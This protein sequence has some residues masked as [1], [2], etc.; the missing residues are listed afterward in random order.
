MAEQF[1][2]DELAHWVGLLHDIGKFHPDF[3]KYLREDSSSARVDHKGAGAWMAIDSSLHPL[4]YPLAAH[5]GGLQDKVDADDWAKKLNRRRVEEA[6]RM[7]REHLPELSSPVPQFPRWIKDKLACEFFIRMLFSSLIDADFLDTEEHFNPAASI[8]RSAEVAIENIQVRFEEFQAAFSGITD[9]PVNR[10][11]HD[12]YLACS[13][14]AGLAPGFFSLTV[15]T[16]GGK[17]RSSLSFALGHAVKHGMRRVI[18][19]IPYTSIIEQ[20]AEVYGKALAAIGEGIVLEHHSAV[21]A[22]EEE[23][24]SYTSWQRLAAENWDAPI[25]VTTAVQFFESLL[26]NKVSRCRKLHN[27]AGSVVIL[28]EVQTLPAQLLEPILD[29]LRQLVSHYNV[30]VVLCTATQPALKQS[31]Y[32]SGLPNTREIAPDPPRLFSILKRVEYEIPARKERWSWENVA[33]EILSS[34]QVLAVVN[35]RRHVLKLLDHLP[36]EHLFHLSTLLCGRHR[37]EVLREIKKRL[38]DGAPC[39][40][41]ST[42]VVEAGVDVDFPVV[43][44]AIGPLDS[45]VQSAGR[46]NREGKLMRDGRPARGRVVIFQPEEAGMP[47]GF[48]RSA[49]AIAQQLLQEEAIDLEDPVLFEKYFTR[50]YPIRPTSKEREIKDLRCSFCYSKVAARFKII[51]EETLPVVVGYPD[52]EQIMPLL[53]ELEEAFRGHSK[54]QLRGI[55]RSLQPFMVH[56]YQNQLLKHEA[57]RS[58]RR[59]APNLDLWEWLLPYDKLRGIGKDYLEPEDCIA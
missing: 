31:R 43:F 33:E 49:T 38:A 40:L 4:L 16:G 12:V 53:D 55:L 11:R 1:G 54:R 46:C 6:Q 39:R 47:G 2:A 18:F 13:E 44:R 32:L 52:K 25:V 5:H 15:P 35:T 34:D 57:S 3:Q 36:E 56:V 10:V 48:Y 42:Q 24:E 26:G 41:V 30:S 23:D 19:V 50:L 37:R 8:S 17:T 28:D 58:V 7:A 14:R 29:V 22:N 27:I 21:D 45:I 59:I 9:D 20:T 51:D